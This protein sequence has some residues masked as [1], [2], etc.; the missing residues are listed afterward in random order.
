MI[1]LLMIL[2]IVLM[3]TIMIAL[4]MIV[5]MMTIMMILLMLTRPCVNKVVPPP[6]HLSRHSYN[7]KIA[8]LN[9]FKII[10]IVVSLIIKSITIIITLHTCP[11][12]PSIWRSQQ[13]QNYHDSGIL[14]H[15]EYQHYYHPTHFSRHSY[16]EN[17][18]FV[19]IITMAEPFILS[20]TIFVLVVSKNSIHS[21]LQSQICLYFLHTQ[22]THIVCMRLSSS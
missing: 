4:M 12:T 14:G 15:K 18:Y 13:V 6:T 1:V 7:L 21:R 3:M 11:D 19:K 2:I 17:N 9:M 8:T 20:I 22:N 16:N 10:T 5:L